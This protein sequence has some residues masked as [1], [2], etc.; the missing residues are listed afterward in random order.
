MADLGSLFV[1]L[2]ADI[3]QLREAVSKAESTLQRY[4]DST[5]KNLGRAEQA[6]RKFNDNISKSSSAIT[7]RLESLKGVL[8]SINSVFASLGVGLSFKKIIDAATEY[9]TALIDMGKVTDQSFEEIEKRVWSLTGKGFGSATELMRGY[10]MV[11]SAGVTEPVRALELLVTA[12]KAAKAAH[13]DQASMIR[14]LTALMTAYGRELKSTSEAAD[15][16]FAT[17]RYGKTTVMELVPVLGTTA[18]LAHNVG[19]NAVE[20]AGA[21]SLVTQTAGNTAEAATQLEALLAALINPTDELKELFKDFGGAI[22]AIQKLGF[23]ETLR[24]IDEAGKGSAE[25][26]KQILGGRKEATLGFLALRM[27]NFE[28]LK[29]L[30][31]GVEAGA[32]SAEKAWQQFYKGFESVWG[33]FTS[34]IKNNMILIGK[35]VLPILSEIIERITP[36]IKEIAASIR[37]SFHNIVESGVKEYVDKLASAFDALVFIVKAFIAY[38]LAIVFVEIGSAVLSCARSVEELLKAVGALSAVTMTFGKLSIASRAGLVGLVLFGGWEAGKYLREVSS[39]FREITDYI[40]EAIRYFVGQISDY[41]YAGF[42]EVEKRIKERLVGIGKEFHLPIHLDIE[43]TERKLQEVWRKVSERKGKVLTAYQGEYFREFAAEA[44]PEELYSRPAQRYVSAPGLKGVM[45]PLRLRQEPLAKETANIAD[46][47]KEYGESLSEV[48]KKYDDYLSKLK[49]EIE[50]LGKDKVVQ[51]AMNAARDIGIAVGSKEY[52]VILNLLEK[53]TELQSKLRVQ[54]EIEEARRQVEWINKEAYERQALEIAQR[55]NISTNSIEYRQLVEALKIRDEMVK[56]IEQEKEARELVERTEKDLTFK[57][58]SLTLNEFESRRR[59][60][61]SWYDETKKAYDLVGAD[62]SKLYE[63]MTLQLMEYDRQE[64]ES[65]LRRK[66]DSE[67]YYE[68]HKSKLEEQGATLQ[69]LEEDRRKWELF[70]ARGGYPREATRF[71]WK[72]PTLQ[73][74]AVGAKPEI[75]MAPSTEWITRSPIEQVFGGID[76]KTG[77]KFAG[78]L[79]IGLKDALSKFQDFAGAVSEMISGLAD[80]ISSSMTQAFSDVIMGTKNMKEAFAKMGEVVIET[81]VQIIMKLL[82][83]WMIEQMIKGV[84][85]L[86]GFGGGGGAAVGG[87]VWSQWTTGASPFSVSGGIPALGHSGGLVA[88]RE[89]GI[90]PDYMISHS[91]SIAKEIEALPKFHDGAFLV[92]RGKAQSYFSSVGM[93][94]KSDEVPAVLQVGEVV[95]DKDRAKKWAS[96]LNFIMSSS[97][98]HDGG[99]VLKTKVSD[100]S[101]ST[102]FENTVFS[103]DSSRSIIEKFHDGGMVGKSIGSVFGAGLET[104][105]GKTSSSDSGNVVINLHNNTGVPAT[106]GKVEQRYDPFTGDRVFDIWLSAVSSDSKKRRSLQKIIK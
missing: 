61:K 48:A 55:E 37:T 35:D 77:R 98:F 1:T 38:R 66:Q 43:S 53:K 101:I 15:I 30:I 54:E 36:K 45:V 46:A 60:L 75:A 2:G 31:S 102:N 5:T 28:L 6:W 105:G 19:L 84:T 70:V 65:I 95:I 104:F 97:K 41:V 22:S 91:S 103:Y 106:A 7:S 16:L 34:T 59:E 27:E 100:K 11:I 92:D 49:F 71:E 78:G 23:V 96:V 79:E 50:L 9:Q 67:E 26:I 76:E 63:Y 58:Q 93:Q 12:S 88:G 4:A 25:A 72:F 68:W 85:S 29:N 56:K 86:F 81:I 89:K 44:L 47:V 20:M 64:R 17:E 51:E 82:I 74:M 69:Q 57:I 18:N 10:Y 90:V 80:T 62:T 33:R 21:L 99:V 52:Q 39:I 32:G 73:E 83:M 87:G 24:R 42:L 3:S 14:V 13:V 8:F 94:L 40:W